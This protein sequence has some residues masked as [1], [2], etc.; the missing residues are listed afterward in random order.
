M[1]KDRRH[2]AIVFRDIAGY[3]KLMGLDEDQAFGVFLEEN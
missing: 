2:S 3:T 1:P